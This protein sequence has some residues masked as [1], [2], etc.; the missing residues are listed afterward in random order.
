MRKYKINQDEIL[1]Y[2]SKE[3]SKHVQE[4][5]IQDANRTY[6]EDVIKLSKLK[7]VS[8]FKLSI[9]R[10]K[11]LTSLNYKQAR[12]IFLTRTRIL[13]IKNN[14]KNEYKEKLLDCPRCHKATDNEIHLIEECG[15]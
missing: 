10:E 6:N 2:T 12:I 11:Y 9:E 4:L 8:Q 5:A 3:W 13:N 7:L 14:H 15:A 1:N